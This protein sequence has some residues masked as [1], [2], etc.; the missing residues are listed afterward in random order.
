MQPFGNNLVVKTLT[1][2]QLKALL[3]QQFDSGTNT[4]ARPNMLLP[5]QGFFFAYDLSRPAGQRIVEMRF[6]G[7]PID[8]ATPYRVTVVNFLSSGGDNFTVLT[9]GADPTD[10]NIVDVEASEAYLKA[11]GGVTKLGR[12]EDR[13]PKP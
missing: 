4:V 10:P 2:A 13:T 5:S 11:G 8:P 9:Q 6:D 1:G 12:I 3:E 7:K